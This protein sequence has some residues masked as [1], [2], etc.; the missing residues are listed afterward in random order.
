M[1][2]FLMLNGH[3][4]RESVEESERHILDVA[5]GHLTREELAEWLKQHLAKVS[6]R[7]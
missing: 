6:R 1:E 4:V 2:T 5:S 7:R 3:E